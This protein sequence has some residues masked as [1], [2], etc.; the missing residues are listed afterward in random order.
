[1]HLWQADLSGADLTDANLQGAWVHGADLSST[2]LQG[3]DLRDTQ[4]LDVKELL[5]AGN[6]EDIKPT[7]LLSKVREL[8]RFGA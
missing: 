2:N 4:G 7:W 8:A 5:K 6:F 1:M 3:A